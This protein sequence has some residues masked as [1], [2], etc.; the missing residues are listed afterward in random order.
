MRFDKTLFRVGIESLFI[1]PPPLVV[2]T[3]DQVSDHVA[4]AA[5]C[6]PSFGP[7]RRLT[8]VSC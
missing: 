3:N 2:P 8:R 1:A 4:G 6:L 5:N 7:A